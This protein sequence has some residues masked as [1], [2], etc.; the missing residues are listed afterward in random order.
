M[1]RLSLLI[2]LLVQLAAARLIVNGDGRRNRV[3]SVAAKP[4]APGSWK[5]EM[6]FTERMIAGSCARG[7]A[8]WLP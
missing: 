7:G 8:Q 3:D 6:L 4:K 5:S 1:A 2:A